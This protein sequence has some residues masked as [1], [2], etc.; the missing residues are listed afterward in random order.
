MTEP[1]PGKPA[2]PAP[3]T[4]AS[5]PPRAAPGEEAVL[6]KAYDLDLMRQLWPFIRPHWKLLV[7]WALFMPITIALELAQP[8]MFRYALE[9]H[10][11]GRDIG[12]L[13]L[14]AAAYMLLVVAQG[15]SAFCETWFLQLAGQRT[16][17][18][19]RIA[20]FDHVLAQRAA[21][22]DQIP[23]GRLMTRMTNDI[24]SLNEMFAQGAITLIADFLKMLAIV[25]VLLYYDAA[26]TLFVFV[27]LPFLIV[28]VE[29][30]RRLMRASFRQIRVRLAAM[31]AFAQEHLS[32]IKVV[33]LLGRASTAQREYDEIN[34]GHRDAYLGQIRADSS[35]Y[36]LVEAT[37]AVAVAILIWY[38]AGNRP[39]SNAAVISDVVMFI[40][41]A[42]KFFMP[43][44]DL[45]QKYAVMQGAMAASERIF[46]LLAT[47]D[48]DGGAPAAQARDGAAKPAFAASRRMLQRRVWAYWT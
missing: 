21:F 26:L 7:A 30:A 10:I 36:A 34:A 25:G 31:N 2:Q 41:F 14:D 42:D 12:A 8:V 44:R 4:S 37:G 27:T 3:D 1:A 16:M 18:A 17:H 40:G 6:G 19:L 29:Y 48:F 32:G 46:Q 5:P 11:L 35:M 24:E 23:V 15:G 47:R 38:A 43:V 33:Q 13:P 45:S 28:L 22:F 20:I 39:A 9:H